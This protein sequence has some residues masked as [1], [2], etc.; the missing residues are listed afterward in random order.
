[1]MADRIFRNALIASVIFH[2]FIFYNWPPLRNLSI[3]KDYKQLE[4]TYCPMKTNPPLAKLIDN[5]KN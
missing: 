3:L 4:L 2:M 1:M 5:S